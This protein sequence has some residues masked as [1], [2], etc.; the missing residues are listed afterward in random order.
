MDSFDLG[1]LSDYDFEVLCRDLFE[2]ILGLKIEIFARGAD[3]GVDLRH[4]AD[5]GSSVVIQCKHWARTGRTKLLAHMRDKERPKIAALQPARYI[6]A[7]SV[8]LTVD[9]KDNLLEDLSPYVRSTG[10]LYGAEQIAEELRKRPG[11]VR[12]HFR[13]WL[14]S[15]AVL[16]E[17]LRQDAVIRSADLI[18][19]LDDA[20]KTFVPTLVFD[21]A[22]E[23]LERESVCLLAGIPGIGKTTIA[24]MLARLH[25]ENGCQVVDVSRDVD[26]IDKAWLE[27]TPQ[28]FYYDDFLGQI[29]LDHQLGKNEDRRLLRVMRR[30]RRTPG[31][32]LVLTTR[33]YILQEAKRRFESLDDGDLEPVTCDVQA[34][35]L[36]GSTRANILYNHVYYSRISG[37]EKRKFADASCWWQLVRHRNFSPRL[38]ESTVRL[39]AREG[40]ANVTDV[41]LANFENPERIWAHA[42]EEDLDE[43]AVHLLEVLFTFDGRTEL[44]ELREAW[45]GYRSA[46]GQLD[47][48]RLFD[49]AV[50][51]LDGSMIETGLRF[52]RFPAPGGMPN[53]VV[54]DFHNPS[55]RDY[56]LVRVTTN[57]VPL[58][59]LIGSIDDTP[60]IRHLTGFSLLP[61]TPL[62]TALRVAADSLTRTLIREYE[63]FDASV[64]HPQDESWAAQLESLLR[65]ADTLASRKLADFVTG[66]I[67]D[68]GLRE[69]RDAESSHLSSLALTLD[70]TD[71]IPDEIRQESIDEVL[72]EMNLRCLDADGSLDVQWKELRVLAQLLPHLHGFRAADR[73]AEVEDTMI[74]L[75]HHELRA[76]QIDAVKRARVYE[77]S[78]ADLWSTLEDLLDFAGHVVLSDD[79]RAGAEAALN[80]LD[81]APAAPPT[82]W[83][84]PVDD[85]AVTQAETIESFRSLLEDA[86]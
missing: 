85:K 50:K 15:T 63:P 22:R 24:K 41:L 6:L 56:L 66:K 11:L 73:F 57:L 18:D 38:V 80:A 60:R 76:W 44:D 61:C 74:E 36:S 16:Q 65:I 67:R 39:A 2:E 34:E 53:P 64:L 81:A 27:D 30:V 7:T 70:G 37:E 13:L 47:S 49:R 25:L 77:H 29:A 5:D 69:L 79:L 86:G 45:S 28:L 8:E 19:E 3:G 55:I 9:A 31:K 72:N 40:T 54:V 32:L 52:G 78:M 43:P 58:E 42:I 62:T 84:M 59:R 4:I 83:K 82:A 71:L 51:V 75:L 1:R 46:L 48:R 35:S 14:S 20:A 33:E 26:E 10:D 68:E 17:V 12:R 21:A 23:L